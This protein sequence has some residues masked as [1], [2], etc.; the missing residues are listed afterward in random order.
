MVLRPTGESLGDDGPELKGQAMRPSEFLRSRRPELFSDSR[1]VGEPR[2]AREVFEYHL[3][4]LTSRKQEIEFEAFCRRLAEKEICPN[5]LPQ[6]GPT[7]G[8]DSKVDAETYPVADDIS[9]RW[10]VGSPQ[11]AGEGRWAF[12]FSAKE[13]WRGKVQQDVKKIAETRRDYS[14][15]YFMT[16]QFVKDRDRAVVEDALTEKYNIPVRILDRNWITKS[17]FEHDRLRL[18][19]DALSLTSYD[20]EAHRVAGPHDVERESELAQLEQQIADPQ[21]YAG[22]K[23]QL[24]ED[25]LRAALICRGLERPR[26]EVENQL[27]RTDRIAKRVNHPQQRLRVAYERALTALWWYDDFEE[28]NKFY[29]EVETLALQSDQ[30]ADLDRLGNL[31]T[32]LQHSVKTGRLRADAAKLGTRTSAIKAALD[33]MAA[34]KAR[35]G[36][37][38]WAKALGLLIDLSAAVEDPAGIA[39][40]LTGLNGV[41]LAADGLPAFPL[42]SIVKLVTEL[43]V[44]LSDNPAYDEL[45]ETMTSVM[46][47]RVSEAE[48]GRLLSQRGF[49][50]LKCNKSYDAIRMFGRAQLKLALREQREEFVMALVGCGLAYKRVGLL[51]AARANHLAA[52]NQ[53]LSEYW[54]HG[55]ILPAVRTS[56]MKLVWM[57]LGLG[58]V[59]WAL[60]WLEAAS[61]ISFSIGT[62]ESRSDE[63]ASNEREE[64]DRVLGLLLLKTDLANLGTLDFLPEI[65]DQLGLEYARMALLFAL[66]YE[67]HLRKEGII[68]ESEDASAVLEFFQ[69]W[70]THPAAEAVPDRPELLRTST[71]ELR[72]GVLG[73]EIV[74]QA[75]NRLSSLYLGEAVL[76]A[77]EALLATSLEV[78]AGVFPYVPEFRLRI[79]A[80]DAVAGQPEYL[81]GQDGSEVEIRHMPDG[82]S[83]IARNRT[84][85]QSWLRDLVLQIAGHLIAGG[86]PTSYAQRLFA[87]EQGLG[88]AFSFSDPSVLVRNIIGDAPRFRMA[89]WEAVAGAT[90]FPLKRPS[91]W[92]DNADSTT[93]PPPRQG[94]PES[95]GHDDTADGPPATREITHPERHVFSLINIALWNRAKWNA[96]LYLLPKELD[97]LPLLAIGFINPDAGR[98]IFQGWCAKLGNV[99]ERDEIA[100]SIVRGINRDRPFSYRI[101]I[102]TNP[103]MPERQKFKEIIQISRINEMNPKDS[104]NLDGFLQRF[105]SVG[106]YQ[107]VP[108]LYEAEHKPPE[109]FYDLWIGKRT[110]VVRPAWQVS[111]DDSEAIA[112]RADDSPII[113]AGIDDA[114]VLR[115]LERARRRRTE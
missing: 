81:F 114:P 98:S 88:R 84:V 105:S 115:V 26:S 63:A 54:E 13:D 8:G 68:P 15:I 40:A 111:V 53:A 41:V 106:R 61:A 70:L 97:G 72:S 109:I 86:D 74:A 83:W 104:R 66:G 50:K 5:L 24:A 75:E 67:D 94:M 35:P 56:L 32:L 21:R 99:D 33:H 87:D 110:L 20:T 45:F 3:D 85:F 112:I 16:N 11:E 37:A 10:Y 82:T 46:A 27:A 55:T 64:Q 1:L 14:L 103:R 80:S 69:Q 113:P 42:A 7:G 30:A 58:R 90:R 9:L 59:P 101:A 22:V 108:A 73:C 4:T 93:R 2:L 18:A 17:I 38:L 71:I 107:M 49:Q 57:E 31:L 6:T 100:I 102:G 43:G 60:Q 89:D 25:C 28:L 91:E 36:N 47:R 51:W 19:I 79:V 52:A 96:T 34:D 48:A 76:A 65:L 39:T 44:I 29:G 12:A 23:Y 62:P 78:R 95:T 77:L 92:F